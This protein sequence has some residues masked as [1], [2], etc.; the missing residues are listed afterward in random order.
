MKPNLQSSVNKMGGTVFSDPDDT[1]FVK[2]TCIKCNNVFWRKLQ[3]INKNS[4]KHYCS[5]SCRKDCRLK[6]ISIGDKLLC[7]KCKSWKTNKSFGKADKRRTGYRGWCKE[8]EQK[9]FRDSGRIY[10]Q[11]EYMK[12]YR[13]TIKGRYHDIARGGDKYSFSNK[14][15]TFEEFSVWLSSQALVCSYCGLNECDLG[16]TLGI[17]RMDS[18]SGYILENMCFCCRRC[19]TVKNNV[20]SYEEFKEIGAKYLWKKQYSKPKTIKDG[21]F[22]KMDMAN[23]GYLLV[24]PNNVD[25]IEVFKPDKS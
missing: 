22:C 2:L 6:E 17:D 1:C 23:G 13:K 8:C 25:C 19:N 21:T 24:N 14:M 15:F 5:I 16:T 20:F 9:D 7:S 3:R 18:F 12:G 11:R 4:N 10:S